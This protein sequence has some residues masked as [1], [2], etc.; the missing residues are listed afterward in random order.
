[1][2][3]TKKSIMTKNNYI[4]TSLLLIGMLGLF[5]CK[6]QATTAGAEEKEEEV[7]PE[8]AFKASRCFGQCVRCIG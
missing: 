5:S 6:K 2:N 3:S 7:L 8:G 4:I 1:M